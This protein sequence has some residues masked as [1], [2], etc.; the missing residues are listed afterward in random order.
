M[1]KSEFDNNKIDELKPLIPLGSNIP[2]N[3]SNDIRV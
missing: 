1:N 3:K 2:K